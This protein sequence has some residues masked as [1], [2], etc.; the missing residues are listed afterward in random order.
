MTARLILLILLPVGVIGC[1]PC[2]DLCSANKDCFDPEL[3][4]WACVSE[5]KVESGS[6]DQVRKCADCML[7]E[8]CD[9]LPDAC[10][11]DCL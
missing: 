7:G 1:H 9:S 10:L 3:D 4:V 2:W 11:K 6:R 8:G 5:C